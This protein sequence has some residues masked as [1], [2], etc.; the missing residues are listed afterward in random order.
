MLEFRKEGWV[1]FRFLFEEDNREKGDDDYNEDGPVARESRVGPIIAI[2][3]QWK[4]RWLW[5]LVHL[6]E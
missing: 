3:N 2:T 1:P 6:L 5:L 4:E